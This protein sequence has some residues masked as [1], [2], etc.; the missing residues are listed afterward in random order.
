MAVKKIYHVHIEK[1]TAQFPATII[2]YRRF[3]VMGDLRLHKKVSRYEYT[4][5]RLETIQKVL[6]YGT[7][8][9]Q[10]WRII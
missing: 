1:E 9:S 3:Y 5:K 7:V 6:G 2:F 8:L 10:E 4:E